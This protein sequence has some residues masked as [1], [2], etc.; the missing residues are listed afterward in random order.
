MFVH[1]MQSL[2]C[3]QV[4][5]HNLRQLL[6]MKVYQS[7]HC[8]FAVACTFFTRWSAQS[9]GLSP[10]SCIQPQN[11]VTIPD[12]EESP[13]RH[14][15]HGSA[16]QAEQM[17]SAALGETLPVA[18]AATAA[19]RSHLQNEQ[20]TTGSTDH[21][22]ELANRPLVAE[23][24]AAVAAACGDNLADMFGLPQH[25]N[26][27]QWQGQQ[28]QQRQQQQQQQQHSSG[29]SLEALPGQSW[30]AVSTKLQASALHTFLLS[31]QQSQQQLQGAMLATAE[32]NALLSQQQ[33]QQQQQQIHEQM[34]ESTA[35][36]A[37]QSQKQTLPAGFGTPF[38]PA[39]AGPAEDNRAEGRAAS[40][41]VTQAQLQQD[42]PS[43]RNGSQ[44]SSSSL[45]RVPETPDSAENRSQRT[46]S[47]C[48]EVANLLRHLGH[49][50][51]DYIYQRILQKFC[52]H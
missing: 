38:A 22:V 41:T 17:P 9:A 36:A 35:A 33:H 4:F 13:E 40:T 20:L 31:Q 19:N 10:A 39:P 6:Y 21:G 28:S 18:V 7:Q 12:S 42:R 8:H 52:I 51:V 3:C 34:L 29:C 27:G 37:Q 45:K 11:D 46:Q 16:I 47:P 2:T 25:P 15:Q 1:I 24:A 44:P 32:A 5:C 49:K 26:C 14:L 23:P 43:L 50:I 48:G 30:S